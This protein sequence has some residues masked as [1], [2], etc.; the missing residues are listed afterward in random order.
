MPMSVITEDL[1]STR[2]VEQTV[3]NVLD[4]RLIAPPIFR[5]PETISVRRPTGMAHPSA[6][7]TRDDISTRNWEEYATDTVET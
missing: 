2:S 4:G 1:R 7:F 3:E 6:S 5:E